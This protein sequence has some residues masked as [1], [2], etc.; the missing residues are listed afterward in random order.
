M[1]RKLWPF[2]HFGLKLLAVGLAVSLWFVVSGEETVERGL[3]VPL[4]LEQFPPGLELQGD[5]PATVDVRVRGASGT[6]GRVNPAD[7]VAVLDL[8]GASVGRRLFHL[9]PEQVRAP[10]GVDVVQVTPTTVALAF[11][12]TATRQVKVVPAVDGKPAPGY[13]VG[14]ITTDPATVEVAGPESS[15][16]R[17]TEALTEPILVKGAR[18]SVRE[19]VTIGFLDPELRLKGPRTATVSVEI[20]PGPEER[21]IQHRPVHLR[22]LAA[23][24][25]ARAV[26]PVV[27]VSVR[28]SRE[29]LN[30]LDVDDVDAY[31]DLTGLGSG[32]YTL[33]V[34]ADATADAGVTHVNPPTVQVHIASDKR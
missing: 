29:G 13:V 1:M 8:H 22:H 4:E 21:T 27:D 5:A 19:S 24:L 3:R 2:R 16:S 9:S 20:L 11:E 28:G 32:D 6:L 34:R 7:I 12:K 31:V 17:A 15:I 10:F 14:K 26:P 33:T 25:T 30:R 18:E 23:G